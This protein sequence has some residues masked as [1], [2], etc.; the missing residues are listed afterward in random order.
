MVILALMLGLVIGALAVALWARAELGR[1][2]DAITA[3][4]EKLELV[5]LSQSQWND[6]LKSLTSDALTSSS[7]SLLQLAETKLQPIAET[8]KRY[9][10]AAAQL[11]TK[12]LTEVTAVGEQL[13]AV[14]QGQS[15]LVSETSN[16]VTALRSP[17][18]RGRW[19][20][21]QLKRVVEFAGMVSHCDFIE[22]ATERDDDG[23]LLRPDLIVKLAGGKNVLVDSKAPLEAYLDAIAAEDEPARQAA[24]TRHARL[25]RD[26]MTQLGQ[27]RY[28]QTFGPTPEFVIMFM[29]DEGF[30]RAALDHDPALLDA[31]L[32]GGVVRVIPA[33]PT[34]LIAMLRTV[35]YGWQQEAV[36]DSAR[37][38]SQL[39]REL[40][41]RLGI[42]AKHFSKIGR[43]LDS[44]VGSY[45]EAVGSFETRVLVTARK[46]PERGITADAP[47]EAPVV[48]RQTRPF[49][50][51]ELDVADDV[52]ELPARAAD[53]A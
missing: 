3:A 32:D 25:V 43:S 20:E 39:G 28:W 14:A 35:A 12:R 37:E 2:N 8:L 33:S 22:Q 40:Y 24:L 18:V 4:A 1:R 49:F 47:P 45:N 41:E 51:P 16:L 29:G 52:I 53:A 36:A 17:N 44:A 21:I 31:G 34:T 48:E 30:F 13:K 26:H 38:V 11:E 6:H 50:A 19:G 10:Q 46:F 9:E 27:K 23:R 42:F 7:N 5:E 15:N